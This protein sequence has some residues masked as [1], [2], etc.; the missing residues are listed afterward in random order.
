VF[1]LGGHVVDTVIDA[2][3]EGCLITEKYRNIKSGGIISLMTGIERS[4]T[5]PDDVDL[6]PDTQFSVSIGTGYKFLLDGGGQYLR[7]VE[8]LL[9]ACSE[10]RHVVITALGEDFPVES[11]DPAVRS[12][13]ILAGPYPDLSPFYTHAEFLLDSVPF[14]GS[15][16]RLETIAC[17]TPVL[18]FVN[19]HYPFVGNNDTLPWDHELIASDVGEMASLAIELA[20]NETLRTTAVQRQNTYYGSVFPFRT[21][22]ER[23]ERLL[24]E[25]L[26]ERI[27]P[28]LRLDQSECDSPV[29]TF[30]LRELSF[31][32]YRKL[33]ADYCQRDELIVAVPDYR[34][35][36]YGTFLDLRDGVWKRLL[37]QQVSKTNSTGV[38]DRMRVFR[39][40]VDRNELNSAP[41]L[42]AYGFLAAVGTAGYPLFR[43]AERY[44]D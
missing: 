32:E 3:T 22:G 4:D 24:T 11:I 26:S 9:K 14:G 8:R 37:R 38:R 17:D 39:V 29:S 15:M 21:V 33:V 5:F 42:L 23:W 1:W 7:V 19:P 41:K 18:A 30:D 36:E 6:G 35:D 2:R 40:A 12:R 34:M 43:M 44:V 16:V 10:H 20:R 28:G 27:A 31:G 13:L 25:G